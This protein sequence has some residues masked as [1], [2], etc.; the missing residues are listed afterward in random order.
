ML[1]HHPASSPPKHPPPPQIRLSHPPRTFPRF[2]VFVASGIVLW[3]D[4]EVCV[5]HWKG[6]RWGNDQDPSWCF[7][8][9]LH[10]R[11]MPKHRLWG[12][13]PKWSL[14][15][16]SCRG[17]S[18]TDWRAWR[19]LVPFTRHRQD[20]GGGPG[21]RNSWL[22]SQIVWRKILPAH[23]RMDT[24]WVF[25]LYNHCALTLLKRRSPGLRVLWRGGP[26]HPRADPATLAQNIW[27][28]KKPMDMVG[29][30][31]PQIKTAQNI[32]KHNAFWWI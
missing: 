24:F 25:I 7:G 14:P 21:R 16:Y 8:W 28:S 10:S 5:L 19:H 18:R 4:G 22:V 32:K 1:H 20:Q 23:E 30:F 15:K 3:G 12:P 9:A 11:W 2:C 29:T 13:L 27:G 31:W 26:G 17:N 6:S